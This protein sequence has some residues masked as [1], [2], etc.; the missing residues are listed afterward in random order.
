MTRFIAPS[1]LFAACLAV[2]GCGTDPR[3]GYIS[4]AVGYINDAAGQ[5]GTIKDK[6]SEAIKKAEDKKLNAAAL[7]E[8]NSAIESL[9]DLGKKMQLVKQRTDAAGASITEEQKE[10]LRKNYQGKIQSALEGLEEERVKLQK[11][12][13]EAEAIDPEGVRDLRNQLTQAEGVFAVLARR[14]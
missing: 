13:Q 11:T 8:A 5:I 12:L 2:A 3:E 1:L 14:N 6:V 4:S 9:R 10:E 7:R